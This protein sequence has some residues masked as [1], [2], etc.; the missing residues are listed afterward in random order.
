M[1]LSIT[2]PAQ[3]LLSFRRDSAS[4]G[5]HRYKTAFGS[6]STKLRCTFVLL[7]L[8][9]LS[10]SFYYPLSARVVSRA[11]L[12]FIAG[13]LVSSSLFSVCVCV[14]NNCLTLFS[15]AIILRI[16]STPSADTHFEDD[17]Y[18]AEDSNAAENRALIR[19]DRET[20]PVSYLAVK[21]HSFQ[22]RF[23]A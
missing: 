4:C 6:L 11:S 12:S 8:C 20:E 14:Y 5:R 23:H 17:S 2:G 13:Y 21:F 16:L 7:L 15:C 10:F 1:K 18:E 22:R 9:F 3:S 19:T